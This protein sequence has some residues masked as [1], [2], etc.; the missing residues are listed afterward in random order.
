[1]V[2]RD[3][4]LTALPPSAAA[5]LAEV[6]I[7]VG[8][9]GFSGHE[10]ADRQ[11]R[12][13]ARYGSDGWRLAHIVRGRVVA[14]AAAIGEYEEAYRVFLRA[15]RPIVAFLAEHCGNVYDDSVENVFDATYEQPHT[16]SNHYQDIAVRR[17][18]A[19][20]ADDPAWPEVTPTEPGEVDLLDLGTGQ[21]HRVPRAYGF[22][23]DGLLQIRE[24]DSPGFMLSPA[25]VPV[26]DPALITTLPGRKEWYH[27]E[28]CGH[29]SVEAFW[30]MSKVVEVRYDRFLAAGAARA[31]PL[32]SG[33]A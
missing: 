10:K 3:D 6:W 17:A 24:P 27:L 33:G 31:D 1:M 21:R 26:H 8:L 28:G 15:R 12:L 4:W 19:Q 23:G 18:V 29:L 13:D 9:P 16:A 7:P 2:D 22:R 11:T 14:P 20:L 32:G 25:V 5:N 30:Q